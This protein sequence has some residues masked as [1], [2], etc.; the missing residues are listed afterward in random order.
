MALQGRTLAEITD[1]AG[2]ER[3]TRVRKSIP[4]RRTPAETK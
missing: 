2:L 1:V 3:L 4:K